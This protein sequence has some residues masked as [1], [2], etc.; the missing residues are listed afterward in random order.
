MDAELTPI[1]RNCPNCGADQPKDLGLGRDPWVIGECGQCGFAYLTAAASYEDLS[2]L[3][4]WEKA[5]V[6]EAKRRKQKQPIVQWLDQKTRWRLH[7]F[8]RPET[9]TFLEKLVPGGNIVDIGC[10]N[11]KVGLALPDRYTPY[12]VE[13]SKSLA[14][15]ADA[16]FRKRGGFCVHAPSAE[17]LG[18]F[19]PNLFDGA[20]LNSYLEHEAKPLPVLEALARVMKPSGVAIIKVPNFGSWNAAVM[21][22]GWCGI[23]LP[24]HVNYFT[25]QS[26]ANMAAKAGFAS[27]FPGSANLPTNDNFWAFL[28]RE[29]A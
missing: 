26:L 12:G 4:S 13:I 20:M 1:A 2:E 8:P 5:I 22:S 15:E 9:K 23:R 19:E 21:K 25:P 7:M 28:R 10:G 3:Y 11:G 29:A 16:E 18:Q 17:G 24:D 27:D 14:A 6:A